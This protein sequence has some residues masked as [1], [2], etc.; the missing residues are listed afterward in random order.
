MDYLKG[1][2]E[3]II[4]LSTNGAKHGLVEGL[5]ETA[6]RE[7]SEIQKMF[8]VPEYA[9][10]FGWD[11]NEIAEIQELLK[12]RAVFFACPICGGTRYL[13]SNTLEYEGDCPNCN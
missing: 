7:F 4:A 2:K 12:E 8:S 6:G 10:K 11:Y 9:E 1:T 3:K 5:T 13:K